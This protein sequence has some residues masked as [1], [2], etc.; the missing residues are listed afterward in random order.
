MSFR[1][2]DKADTSA[3]SA[4]SE[5]EAATEPVS[6]DSVSPQFDDKKEALLPIHWDARGDQFDMP[7]S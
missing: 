5:P 2:D 1:P 6:P 4:S 7:G 3:D